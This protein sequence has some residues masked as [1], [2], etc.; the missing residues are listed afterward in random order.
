[1]HICVPCGETGPLM[2]LTSL[3]V[4]DRDRLA[5]PRWAFQF[6]LCICWLFTSIFC[7][8]HFNFLLYIVVYATIH[9]SWALELLPLSFIQPIF[10]MAE[11]SPYINGPFRDVDVYPFLTL[12][13]WP[14]RL[15][16]THLKCATDSNTLHC[17]VVLYKLCIYFQFVPFVPCSC[18][19]GWT[20]SLFPFGHVTLWQ[21][22]H[23]ECA[24]VKFYHLI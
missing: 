13:D 4:C 23:L 2:W 16:W 9:S 15:V 8:F 6:G 18:H 3:T 5:L 1:M 10:T 22:T 11:G 7:W 14:G 20:A 17:Q 19:S 12:S 21:Q 24:W